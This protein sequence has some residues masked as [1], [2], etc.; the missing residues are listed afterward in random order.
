MEASLA[1][2]RPG[3][4]I[5]RV[6]DRRRRLLLVLSVASRKGGAIRV[7]TVTAD[8]ETVNLHIHNVTSP[9]EPISTVELPVPFLP[10]SDE[11]RH[12]AAAVLARAN[13]RRSSTRRRRTTAPDG[14]TNPHL[15]A[16][17]ALDA[18]PL[19][20]HPERERLV[21]DHRRRSRLE[22][23]LADVERLTARRGSDLV[24]RFDAVL[25]VLERVGHVDGW[26]LT[27]SGER[28][29]RIYH[30][31]D[32]LLSLTADDGLFDG[33]DAAETAALASCFTYEHRSAEAPPPPVFPTGELARRFRRLAEL[34]ERLNRWERG[35][36]LPETRR[37]DGGFAGAAWAWAAVHGLDL[38]LDEDLTG[39]D[40]VRNTKQLIDLLGQLGDIVADPTSA[41]TCRQAAQALRRGVVQAGSDLV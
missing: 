32:L 20:G 4:V 17:A 33:L 35:A 37:P 25:E 29:R 11:Y 21:Q 19:H 10:R 2:L 16:L 14:G 26:T 23:E 24:R 34:G 13:L 40:F 12:Q 7:R 31:C 5:E 3:D 38:V 41:R 18:H 9:L 39:G 28:L 22:S 6:T 36:R 15:D 27:P 8:A 30:E 1:R